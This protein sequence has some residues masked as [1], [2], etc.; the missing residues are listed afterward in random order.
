M[1]RGSM[2]AAQQPRD[3]GGA[4]GVHPG[5]TGTSRTTETKQTL[6]S[7]RKSKKSSKKSCIRCALNSRMLARACKASSDRE[8]LQ[9]QATAEQRRDQSQPQGHALRR[10]CTERGQN[11]A[12]LQPG[13]MGKGLRRKGARA[14][15]TRGGLDPTPWLARLP[16]LIPGQAA[17]P[18]IIGLT[19]PACDLRRPRRHMAHAS[20][21]PAAAA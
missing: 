12:V 6:S 1:A 14:A 21:A 17:F 18:C 3:D 19:R 5:S 11:A 10:A 15:A 13:L 4:H 7:S 8:T 9:R 20:S 16:N 2:A